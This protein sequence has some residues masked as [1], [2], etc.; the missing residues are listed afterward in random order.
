MRNRN[1]RSDQAPIVPF[2]VIRPQRCV[3]VSLEIDGIGE[4]GVGYEPER[5]TR[6]YSAL[7]CLLLMATGRRRRTGSLGP[8]AAA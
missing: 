3:V 8:A 7:L 1:G 5:C 4:A 6:D 2:V